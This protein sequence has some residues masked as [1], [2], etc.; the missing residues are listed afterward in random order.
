MLHAAV[1]STACAGATLAALTL[2]PGRSWPR[3]SGPSLSHGPPSRPL[4]PVQVQAQVAALTEAA[5]QLA[6]SQ[7]ALRQQLLDLQELLVASQTT[8]VKQFTVRGSGGGGGWGQQ[9]GESGRLPQVRVAS[10]TTAVKQFAVRP[11]G[12]WN[13]KQLSEGH[14]RAT[15]LTLPVPGLRRA[16]TRA[17]AGATARCARP[18]TTAS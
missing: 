9:R 6:A 16:P 15:I 14:R 13:V 11:G 2:S 17:A 5:A 12:L 7:A 1:C 3:A 18:H 4:R 10:Q 8:A